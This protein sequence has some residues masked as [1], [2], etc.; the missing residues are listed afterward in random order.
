MSGQTLSPKQR[1]RIH[2]W[3]RITTDPVNLAGTRPHLRLLQHPLI[4]I[5]TRWTTSRR[6]GLVTQ[7]LVTER[8]LESLAPTSRV[9]L[10]VKTLRQ[11]MFATQMV[12]RG[13]T[14][15]NQIRDPLVCDLTS[16]L[17]CS[18]PDTGGGSVATVGGVEQ[19]GP[20]R[21]AQSRNRSSTFL[22]LIGFDGLMT[23]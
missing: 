11:E 1:S 14:W 21:G 9:L 15:L 2:H 17:P 13:G 19:T 16:I 20:H 8:E 23:L 18:T 4:L 12:M 10:V 3:L 6:T 22:C 5:L 7:L